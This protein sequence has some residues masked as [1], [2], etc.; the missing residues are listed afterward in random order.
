MAPPMS[1]CDLI[2]L[3]FLALKNNPLFGCIVIYLSFYLLK[4]ISLL[5]VMAVMNKVGINICV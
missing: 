4:S 3:S 5:P 2:A 1:F